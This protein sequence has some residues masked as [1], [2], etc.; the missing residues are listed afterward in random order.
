MV[1]FQKL[2]EKTL[3][4]C[5]KSE[6]IPPKHITEAALSLCSKLRKELEE[7][8]LLI[9]SLESTKQPTRSLTSSSKHTSDSSSGY[10]P[11]YTTSSSASK[12]SHSGRF[13][14]FLRNT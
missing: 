11:V 5:K 10:S 1:D 14:Y 12:Y 8:R 7:A 6:F 2:N 9:K 4:E 3:D 13:Y